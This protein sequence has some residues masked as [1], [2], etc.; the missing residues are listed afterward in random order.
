ML[1]FVCGKFKGLSNIK[2]L[3]SSSWI[4]VS[5]FARP[6]I[7]KIDLNMLC[8]HGNGT[9][10][11]TDLLVFSN[12]HET[13]NV[14]FEVMSLLGNGCLLLNKNVSRSKF[15]AWMFVAKIGDDTNR[16]DDG[17][18]PVKDWCP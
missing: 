7:S 15:G 8:S 6:N 4:R 16:Y 10:A 2:S 17:D 12:F 14:T 5:E 3:N 18:Y 1:R 13:T 9:F 11:K